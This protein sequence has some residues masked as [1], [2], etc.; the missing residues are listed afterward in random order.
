MAVSAGGLAWGRDQSPQVP[1]PDPPPP[2]LFSVPAAGPVSPTTVRASRA[3]AMRSVRLGE[4]SSPPRD[5][6]LGPSDVRLQCEAAPDGSIHVVNQHANSRLIHRRNGLGMADALEALPEV[7]LLD[8]EPKHRRA[9][10][11]R[12]GRRAPRNGPPGG[13][14]LTGPT[15]AGGRP[16]L[17]P[18]SRLPIR[19]SRTRTCRSADRPGFDLGF[20]RTR[21]DNNM[22]EFMA[23]ASAAGV[24]TRAVRGRH[25]TPRRDHPGRLGARGGSRGLHPDAGS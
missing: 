15:I 11:A 6:R 19:T 16:E 17:R 20:A 24:G 23:A 18:G 1:P 22:V 4:S 9:S 10:S 13:T 25:S 8:E 14:G 5:H 21:V 3:S 7:S 12:I 2:S